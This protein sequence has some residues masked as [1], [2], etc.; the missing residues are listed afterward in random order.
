MLSEYSTEVISSNDE[1]G[2]QEVE[3][4]LARFDLTFDRNVEY[5]ITIR[6]SGRMV[7]TGSFAGEVLRNVAVDEAIQGGGLASLILSDLMQEQA[8]RGRLHYF[9]YTKPSMSHL[10]V[11]I[12]FKEIARAEPHA[13]LLETGIGSVGK[14]CESVAKQ[15]A[16]LQGTRAAVVVNCNPF[17]K[18]HQAL[19]QKAADENNG[20]IVFVVSEDLSLFPFA[21]RLDLVKA[22]VASMTNVVVV[23]TG[24][25]IV[26]SATFPTYFTRHEDQAAAQTQL[27][28]NLFAEQIAPRLNITER[29][30]GEEPYC[31][32]TN[33]YNTAMTEIL[34]KHGIRIRVMP[35]IEVDGQIVSASKVRE[36]IRQGDWQGIKQAVPAT[37]YR[38]LISTDAKEIIEKIRQSTSRH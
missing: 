31:P 13:A 27:D 35:R 9:I 5:T 17:T 19:I 6:W 34:P 16:W 3:Q 10:F 20:V 8:R 37:T 7:G 32:I 29:Y 21:D 26:S 14:Y 4:F 15:A 38:Y 33:A 36:M 25:Y 12:G 11:N 23:P 2:L 30:I 18:G 1:R 22:G 28:I 24:R